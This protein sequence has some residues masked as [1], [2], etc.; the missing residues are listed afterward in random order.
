MRLVHGVYF[1]ECGDMVY[2]RNV[3]DGHDYSFTP[4][5][6]D[7]LC[8]LKENPGTDLE[9]I[10]GHLQQLY[11]VE[12]P[13]EFR[14]DIRSFLDLLLD[15]HLV[16]MDEM[17]ADQGN[18]DIMGQ[19]ER[20][21]EEK[22][23]LLSATFELTYRCSERCIHCY[24]DDDCAKA[25]APELTLAEYRE[26]LLQ[27]K[28][29]GCIKL[30]LT[31]GEVC[32]RQD[33]IDIARYAVELGFLVDVYTNGISMTEAQFEALCDMKPNSV[34][35]SL[36]SGDPKVHDAITRVPGSFEKTLKRAMMFKCAGVD[37]FFKT[38]VIRQNLDTLDGLFRLGK[39]L[40]IEVNPATSI[41]DTHSGQSAQRFRLDTPELRSRALAI[42]EQY[43]YVPDPGKR[44]MDASVCFAGLNCMSIDPYGGVHPCLAF[45][46][47]VG[48]VQKT[49]LRQIWQESEFL[50]TLRAFRFRDLSP[51]CGEC[52]YRD[53]C[54]VCLGAAY[55]ESGGKLCP[56]C[57][58]CNW[59]R[60]NYETS[61]KGNL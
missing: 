43:R 46:T 56:G 16:T 37:T 11:R 34:S 51:E 40:N 60:S 26:I 53:S 18:P 44:D 48:S 29:M 7:I 27:L 57:D 19:L 2:L 42:L 47:P 4:I 5:V 1:F 23:R 9:E 50:K 13:E 30:L 52:Q 58:S 12:D 21:Y 61:R 14:Q 39:R 55:E 36:Y 54:A 31:G 28:D 15:N 38:V 59:A 32:L 20:I 41:A 22:G 3:N 6:Y 33:L 10:C 17:P 35:F 8:F 49:P 24:V 45:T 25:P